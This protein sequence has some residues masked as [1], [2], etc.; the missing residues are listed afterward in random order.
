MSAALIIF[1]LNFRRMGEDDTYIYP[2]VLHCIYE[3][4]KYCVWRRIHSNALVSAVKIRA[5]SEERGG[6]VLILICG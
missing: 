2:M 1:T 3:S 4:L 5:K 6:R